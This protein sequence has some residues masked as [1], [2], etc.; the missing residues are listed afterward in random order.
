MAVHL[1]NK[2]FT[3]NLEISESLEKFSHYV[4]ETFVESEIAESLKKKVNDEGN[5]T[6][7]KYL[8]WEWEQEPSTACQPAPH[9][10]LHGTAHPGGTWPPHFQHPNHA[11]APGCSMYC[12]GRDK[13]GNSRSSSAN[14][15]FKSPYRVAYVSALAAEETP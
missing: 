4:A 9:A 10:I 7:A 6:D 3:F 1:C 13:E 11:A 2:H 5:Q 15:T 8:S 14:L 12:Q